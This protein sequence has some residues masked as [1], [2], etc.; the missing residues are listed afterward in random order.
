MATEDHVYTL[1]AKSYEIE[2]LFD[3]EAQFDYATN[4]YMID[5]QTVQE[6]YQRTGLDN[7]TLARV[8]CE[9]NQE[10]APGLTRE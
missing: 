5:G 3:D 8:W 10:D 4:N 1:P 6:I 9:V 2:R 7:D